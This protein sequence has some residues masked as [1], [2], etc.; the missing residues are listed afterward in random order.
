MTE[1]DV[2]AR[3]AASNRQCNDR[4]GNARHRAKGEAH[5]KRQTSHAG[6]PSVLSVAQLV[7]SLCALVATISAAVLWNPID[8]DFIYRADNAGWDET[9]LLPHQTELS[10]VLNAWVLASLAVFVVALFGVMAPCQRAA[11]SHAT[12]SPAD[13]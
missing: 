5:K 12:Y 9:L 1:G 13:A 8:T 2:H 11:V 7:L 4:D 6:R 3:G 10:L